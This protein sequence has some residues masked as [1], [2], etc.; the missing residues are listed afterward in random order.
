[1]QLEGCV[2]DAY[3][4][5][6]LLQEGEFD[7]ANIRMLL[8]QRA[9]TEAI[10]DRL[11]WLLDGAEDGQERIFYF[12]GRGA[13]IP[14]Y[15]TGEVVDHL[16]ECLVPYDFDWS[17]ERAVVDDQLYESYS[18][19]AIGTRYTMIFDCCHSGGLTRDGSIR[20][21]GLIPQDEIR[22]RILRWDATG[23]RFDERLVGDAGLRR[24]RARKPQR[25]G[26]EGNLHRL[27]C[28]AELR[29]SQGRF[30]RSRKDFGHVGS[31]MPTI[32]QACAEQELAYEYRNGAQSQGAFTWF[33]AQ[34]IRQARSR[35]GALNWSA[36]I[37]DVR[38]RL[39]SEQYAQQPQLVCPTA[40]V[41]KN[42]PWLKPSVTKLRQ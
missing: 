5:S 39:A 24:E 35:R 8:N 28:A 34:A 22:H 37:G 40:L 36:V 3:L 6:A 14:G 10:H 32:L 25:F 11:G 30:E 19:L 38:R 7:P 18:Q 2:N 42:V 41:K 21:R 13:Q 4:M 20:A 26:R 29:L 9:T 1:M 17:R 16:D 27:G 23:L 33:L 31:F 12:A 15:G